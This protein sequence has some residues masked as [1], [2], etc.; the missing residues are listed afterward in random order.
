MSNTFVTP[1]FTGFSLFR[2][3]YFALSIQV[4]LGS[5]DYF[6]GDGIRRQIIL[7]IQHFY[8]PPDL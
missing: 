3:V 1:M 2:P 4:A 7:F 8:V 6:S 5:V